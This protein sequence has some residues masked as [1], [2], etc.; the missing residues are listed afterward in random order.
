MLKRNLHFLLAALVL[1]SVLSAQNPAKKP[2]TEKEYATWKT[3][4]NIKISPC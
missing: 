2:L 3:V 4:D 1:S